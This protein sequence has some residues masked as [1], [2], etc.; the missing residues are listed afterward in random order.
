PAA[1]DA[2]NDWV[3]D[4]TDGRIDSIVDGL[5]P[6]L[7]MLLANAVYFD[8]EWTT[9]FDNELTRPQPFTREDGGRVEV[10]M[11]S[12]EDVEISR[13]FGPSYSAIELPY[14]GEAF[15][16]IVV[17]PDASTSAR[18]WLAELDSDGWAALTDALAPGR[19]NLLSLPRLELTY[20]GYLNDALQA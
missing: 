7:V 12:I 3:S 17:L 1:A 11:M 18:G 14:G 19:L 16:M 9:Q 2:I 6:A 10:D 15:S 20:D 4:H 13:A 5:D 8:G